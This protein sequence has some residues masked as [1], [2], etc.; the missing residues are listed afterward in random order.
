MTPLRR[1]HNL[2]VPQ[3]AIFARCTGRERRGLTQLGTGVSVPA[4]TT[5]TPEGFPGKEFFIVKDGEATCSVQGATRARFRSG[6]FF[7]EMAL[8]DGGPRTATVTSDTP[9]ELV[10]YSFDEFRAML[11]SSPGVC[12]HL[13]IEMARRLRVP[14]ASV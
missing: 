1:S 4:G 8:L 11:A 7:G 6:D 5:L 3:A 14:D 2:Q 10:V 13:L 9:M 12:R